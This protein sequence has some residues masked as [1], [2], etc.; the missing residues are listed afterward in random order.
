MI[1]GF[2]K[3]NRKIED[4]S[5]LPSTGRLVAV[6][7][8]QNISDTAGFASSAAVTCANALPGSVAFHFALG[9]LTSE[10]TR[11]SA[12]NRRTTP[13]NARYFHL[14][15]RIGP[16]KY[17]VSGRS[18]IYEET[19]RSKGNHE[20]KESPHLGP[21]WLASSPAIQSLVIFAR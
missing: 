20:D 12:R 1:F 16:L 21:F 17:D 7:W 18:G 11:A 3:G 19:E 9:R 13:S 14:S 10:T 4:A 15:L 5:V 6:R 2:V 8:A